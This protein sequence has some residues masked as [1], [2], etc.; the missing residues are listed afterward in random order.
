MKVKALKHVA[1]ATK[2]GV[3]ELRPGQVAEVPDEVVSRNPGWF[4]PVKG[5]KKQTT[6]QKEAAKQ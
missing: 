4:E 2:D 5:G 6:Q 1:F 3:V